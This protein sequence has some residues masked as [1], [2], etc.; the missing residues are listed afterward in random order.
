MGCLL[1]CKHPDVP[2]ICRVCARAMPICKNTS[3]MKRL[4]REDNCVMLYGSRCKYYK[5]YEHNHISN[6]GRCTL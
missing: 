3:L 2:C 5:V 4:Y 6:K 1:E